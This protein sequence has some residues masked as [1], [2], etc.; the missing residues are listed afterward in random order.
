MKKTNVLRFLDQQKIP[1]SVSTYEYD[2]ANF[3]PEK[4]Q[5]FVDFD[6][7]LLYK[8]L[9]GKA[10]KTGHLVAVIPK[11]KTL[12]FKALAK[13]SGNKKMTLIPQKELLPL[14]GYIRGGCSPMGMKK[15]FATYLDESM[16]DFKKVYVNAG[17]RGILVGLSP[18]DL[19][20]ATRAKFAAIAE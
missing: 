9:V 3:T 10:N 14:T 1:Y 19:A 8:T 16:L 17:Q 20:K 12:N 18:E 4:M 2:S 6:I 11:D 7:Q 5:E 15:A 13:T